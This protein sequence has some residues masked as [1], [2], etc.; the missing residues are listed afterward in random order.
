MI[1]KILVVNKYH[2]ISGGAERYFFTIMDAL[3][4]EGI[5]PIPFSVNYA[6]TL[7]SPYQKYFIEPVVKD[8][9]AK[10]VHQKPTL[11]QK[12]QLAK[13][14]VYNTHASRAVKQI[15]ENEK[16][17]LAYFLNFN[18]HISPSAIDACVAA[19]IPVVMRMSDFNLV[20]SPNMYYR[21]GKLCMDCKKGFYHAVI[22]KCVHGS[23]VKS[24]VSAFA[25]SVH[26]WIGVYKKVSAF[27]AP[28]E[29]MKR[30]LI[31]VGIPAAKIYRINTFAAPQLVA[32]PEK[33]NPYILFLGRLAKYKGIDTAIEAFSRIED[34][35]NVSFYV[36]GDEGDDDA[37]RVKSLAQRLNC[38]KVVFM[39]FERDKKKLLEVIQKSL[40][41]VVPSENYEN[42]PNTV[43][44]AFSCSRPVIATRIGSLPD[45]VRD[46]QY[47]L[48]YDFGNVSD[49]SLKM[50]YLISHEREREHMG[51][52]AYEVLLREY[53]KK[54]HLKHLLEVFESLTKDPPNTD[55]LPMTVQ[56]YLI[57]A[58]AISR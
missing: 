55:V 1:S 38:K 36:M 39:P 9:E 50:E 28:T 47:G 8:G 29:F 44:E 45:I 33:K 19:G 24:A 25:L 11:G 54:G 20:C 14:V 5:E 43:L 53:S 2:F 41:V 17:Q 49:L 57:A 16:P 23:A 42:L 58:P 3:R 21:D 40:F 7:P 48:L 15:C 4:E 56:D 31:E 30:E 35:V 13:Q 46:H 27:I 12:I 6:K 26:R 52:N 18:N 34:Q 22:H 51:R 10:M 32:N 37:A